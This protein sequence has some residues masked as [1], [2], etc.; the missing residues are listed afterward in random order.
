MLSTG[1][2]GCTLL[3]HACNGSNDDGTDLSLL[4]AI[5]GRL[6]DDQLLERTPDSIVFVSRGIRIK[7][8]IEVGLGTGY[9]SGFPRI[10][11]WMPLHYRFTRHVYRDSTP[12]CLLLYTILFLYV[13]WNRDLL[14]GGDRV[15]MGSLTQFTESDRPTRPSGLCKQRSLCPRVH[16]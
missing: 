6:C 14:A 10:S 12:D 5:I 8:V 7:S 13:T 15:P 1:A 3:Y 9:V 11:V 4:A 2:I 16:S